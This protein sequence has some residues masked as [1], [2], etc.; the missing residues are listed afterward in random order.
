MS[1]GEEFQEYESVAYRI[2]QLLETDESFRE[3][4]KQNP[5]HTLVAAGIPRAEV[6]RIFQGSD[7]EA[8]AASGRNT[9]PCCDLTCWSSACPA[10]C[11]ITAISTTTCYCGGCRFGTTR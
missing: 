5:E 6:E 8:L 11:S 1:N 3:E 10:T 9:G 4:A 2:V 7:R